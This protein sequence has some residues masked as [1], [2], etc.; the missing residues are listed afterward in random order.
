MGITVMSGG[1][2]RFEAG[3]NGAYMSGLDIEGDLT[4]KS[5]KIEDPNGNWRL[6][7]GGFNTYT[8]GFWYSASSFSVIEGSTERGGLYG[9]DSRNN[10]T[11]EAINGWDVALVSSYGKVRIGA[12]DEVIVGRAG[13]V[14]GFGWKFD[15][16]RGLLSTTISRSSHPTVNTGEVV[17]YNYNN[18]GNTEL[19]VARRNKGDG[20]LNKNKLLD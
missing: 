7:K 19:W 11:V 8:N 14:G 5:G 12:K 18:N 17:I 9:N 15:I 4:I 1:E 3:P 13:S 20:K 2:V 10:V 16:G 6:D